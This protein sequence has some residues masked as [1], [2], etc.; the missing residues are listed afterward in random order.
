MTRN[1]VL[2]GLLASVLPVASARA[3][4]GIT[5][6][7]D[8]PFAGPYTPHFPPFYGPN[9]AYGYY[10]PYYPPYGGM[11]SAPTS[12]NAAMPAAYVQPAQL[13][14]QPFSLIGQAALG[15]VIAQ[16]TEPPPAPMPT[17]KPAPQK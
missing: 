11:D 7:N 12:V 14:A 1:L 3:G 17:G 9:S 4:D 15:Q 13:Y 6:G 16:P 8:I 2:A 10:G 5:A